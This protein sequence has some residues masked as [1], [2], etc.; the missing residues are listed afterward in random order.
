VA[1]GA[2]VLGP[3][4]LAWLPAVLALALALRP[5]FGGPAGVALEMERLDRP[6]LAAM[7]LF[8]AWAVT[9]SALSPQAATGLTA[10]AL[11]A[12]TV[13]AVLGATALAARIA[14]VRP[15]RWTY[16]IAVH[17]VF[18]AVVVLM[19]NRVVDLA[20]LGGRRLEMTWHYNRAAVMAALLTPVALFAAAHGPWRNGMRLSLALLV[21]AAGAAA[22][23]ASDSASAQL[24]FAVVIATAVLWLAARRLTVWFSFAAFAALTLA[25]PWIMPP[26]HALARESAL[27]SFQPGTFA[28]R[29]NIYAGTAAQ[30]SERPWFG[31][32]AEHA[33]LAG[34]VDPETG[35]RAFHN[36]PHSLPLQ[37]WLDLGLVGVLLF[38][39][40]LAAG[41]RQIARQEPR[42]ALMLTAIVNAGLAVLS[43]SHGM[44]QG[45]YLG[46]TGLVLAYALMLV[47]RT[48]LP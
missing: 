23:F 33:R 9:V 31:Y 20:P 21:A 4:G 38:L 41:F 15:W 39:A 6:L 13:A 32:G 22:V 11:A 30:I 10:V 24:A 45:W 47:A 8:F 7:A 44:W 26:L 46:L 37:L 25:L 16:F 1:L 48:R 18:A 2:S 29:L 12:L 27:W 28:A 34:F 5:G 42:A 36:H 19:V 43:V 17:I 3:Q 35:A 40:A 14:D